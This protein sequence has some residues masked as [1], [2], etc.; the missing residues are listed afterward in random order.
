MPGGLPWRRG[1][2]VLAWFFCA[3]TVAAWW[4]KIL[5]YRSPFSVFKA[6][7]DISVSQAPPM[8]WKCKMHSLHT[9]HGKL[10]LN[11]FATRQALLSAPG[12]Q[13]CIDSAIRASAKICV[14]PEYHQCSWSILQPLY[15][16]LS[17]LKLFST[18]FCLFI[19]QSL[20]ILSHWLNRQPQKHWRNA[21]DS[22]SRCMNFESKEGT[23][24]KSGSL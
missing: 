14:V 9:T 15:R 24:Y 5:A 18:R 7:R 1:E 22:E 13:L 16:V 20:R 6:S 12:T 2:L 4:C 17:C 19:E 10:P 21:D 3:K 11:R 8:K 23:G